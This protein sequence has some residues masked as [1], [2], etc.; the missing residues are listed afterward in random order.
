MAAYHFTMRHGASEIE[1]LGIMQFINDVEAFAFASRIV[2]DLET[3]DRNPNGSLEI[4]D[5]KRV[6]GNIACYIKN[7]AAA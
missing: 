3:G 1:L 6:V 4:T 5:G 7:A 2:E